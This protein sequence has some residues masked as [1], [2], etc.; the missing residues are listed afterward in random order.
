MILYTSYLRGKKKK[1][2]KKFY[3]AFFFFFDGTE[4]FFFFLMKTTLDGFSI[5]HSIK[6]RV[7]LS[8]LKST[9]R[10]RLIRPSINEIF[11]SATEI[12]LRVLMGF[13]FIPY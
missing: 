12:K 6:V 2:I 7:W 1:S 5:G 13:E 11:M 8:R 9:Y 3:N 4:V 10:K